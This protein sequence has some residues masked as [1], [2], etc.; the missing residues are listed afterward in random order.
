[1]SEVIKKVLKIVKDNGE[2]WQVQREHIK[3]V[4][5][6]I[7]RN[8]SASVKV[9]IDIDTAKGCTQYTMFLKALEFIASKSSDLKY[10]EDD[11]GNRI[12]TVNIPAHILKEYLED[13]LADVI[14]DARMLAD[15]LAGFETLV[16][17][18]S[19]NKE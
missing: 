18:V 10:E 3:S 17:L 14:T 5:Q 1:M 7:I 6:Y 13:R 4:M 11:Y 16:N 2:D 19:E 9:T 15:F 8:T 12:L